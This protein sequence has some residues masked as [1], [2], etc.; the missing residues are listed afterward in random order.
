MLIWIERRK[1][2]WRIFSLANVFRYCLGSQERNSFANLGLWQQ[3]HSHTSLLNKKKSREITDRT[4][5]SISFLGRIWILLS[6]F[7]W[8]DENFVIMS[9]IVN[10]TKK[11][12]WQRK[13]LPKFLFSKLNGNIFFE[14]EFRVFSL[15]VMYIFTV[16]VLHL[17]TI[18]SWKLR[19]INI[20]TKFKPQIYTP[21]SENFREINFQCNSLVKKL[22]WRNF[23][24]K[25]VGG[26]IRE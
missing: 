8:F 16:L 3:R 9:E 25:I 7:H 15:C 14:K 12:I 11:L 20:P 4:A 24:K 13:F 6:N 17:P 23:C 2:I 21:T 10:F 19:E 22:L 26:F 1:P 5:K 18:F